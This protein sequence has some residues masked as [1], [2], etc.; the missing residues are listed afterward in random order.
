MNVRGFDFEIEEIKLWL[1]VDSFI[2][3]DWKLAPEMD[4]E[5][6]KY[7]YIRNEGKV[8]VKNV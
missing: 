2:I 3:W 5:F 4:I 7:I 8:F 1:N 6:Q